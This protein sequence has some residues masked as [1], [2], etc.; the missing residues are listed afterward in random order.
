ME[1]PLILQAANLGSERLSDLDGEAEWGAHRYWGIWE[2]EPGGLTQ[3][4]QVSTQKNTSKNSWK[5]DTV[6]SFQ[7]N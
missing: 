4:L 6:G 7:E 3:P 1:Q 5:C 2:E